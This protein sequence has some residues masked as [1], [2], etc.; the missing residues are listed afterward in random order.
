MMKKLSKGDL[1]GLLLVF[2]ITTYPNNAIS[3]SQNESV[4]STFIENDGG[5]TI[6]WDSP[7]SEKA[8]PLNIYL[9]GT[10]VV[11][12]FETETGYTYIKMG[13]IMGYIKTDA[14]SQARIPLNSDGTMR[15]IGYLVTQAI[16]FSASE[17]NCYAA[18]SQ[19]S[20][21]I[22]YSNGIEDD[23]TSILL[24][25][26]GEWYQTRGPVGEVNLGFVKATNREKYLLSD[27][28]ISNDTL[29]YTND[30]FV[31]GNQIQSGL[32]TFQ[33]SDGALGMIAS[34]SSNEGYCQ[35]IYGNHTL[36]LR[37]GETVHVESTGLL[38][39]MTLIDKE[40]THLSGSGRFFI[41]GQ[42]KGNESY[43]IS[44]LDGIS[45]GYIR[46]YTLNNKESPTITVIPSKTIE[47]YLH[48]GEFIEIEN[49]AVDILPSH[50]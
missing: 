22:V 30:V 29:T 15:E 41:G 19:E 14:L 1:L 27:M 26:L 47:I 7:N 44:S 40:N 25:D 35:S 33:P 4:F 49:C 36:Y 38:S 24:G 20:K 8:K 3:F 42:L 48:S 6:L 28:L 10:Q 2:M 21:V 31:V 50:G 34:V 46:L 11:P 43:T 37:E 9:D 17:T 16:D 32:Y 18:P 5:E 23:I 13:T 45:N 12:L 39:P